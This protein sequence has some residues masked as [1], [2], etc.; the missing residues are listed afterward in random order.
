MRK[1]SLRV[2][3]VLL[4]ICIS[5]LVPLSGFAQSS[6]I[7]SKKL[8]K[9]FLKKAVPKSGHEGTTA[10]A[11]KK[12]NG[13]AAMAS[14]VPGIDSIVNWTG[15]FTLPGFDPNGN[16]QSVW[17][18]SMIGNSPESNRTT[19]IPA[20]VIP[21]TVNLL[22]A[23]GNIAKDPT[24][25]ALL[26]QTV[27]PAVKDA[28]LHSPMFEPVQYNSGTGQ[29]NDQMQRTEFW[30]RIHH[31]GWDDDFTGWHN[32][33]LPSLKRTQTLSIPFGSWFYA[34]NADGTC[35]AFMIVDDGAFTN[36][37][38]PPT[39]PVDNTTVIGSAELSGDMT[40]H[41]LSAL[42]FNNIFLYE[43]SLANCCVLGFHE[44]DFEPGTAK[45][46]N[47]PRLYVMAYVSWISPGLFGGGFEDI[48]GMSHEFSESFNDPFVN[49]WTPWWLSIDPN[50][51]AGL[52]QDNLE[53]GDVIEFFSALATYP[54][55]HHNRT[56]HPQNEALFPWF[57]ALSP[58]T[59]R[60]GAYSFP[61]ET[62]LTQLS[63]QNLPPGCE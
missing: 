39:Y 53:T 62:T 15:Q 12:T 51:G 43:G 56:Y 63:A 21:V 25:G 13:R 60:G 38:F 18:Y 5:S 49:N 20:S 24:S 33:L 2:P 48:T 14:G 57:A 34:L 16:P 59:A 28:V 46:G 10:M 11:A 4:A 22:D 58:S 40:T 30:N 1:P 9:D 47:L 61:D 7:A 27:T 3:C 19:L 8:P 45:N 32:F 17:P 36:G 44:Y 42:L 55:A 23:S 37:L 35:C 54:V 41:D 26:T 31:G 29:F 52:C 50:S 6:A